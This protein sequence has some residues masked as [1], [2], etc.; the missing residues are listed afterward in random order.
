MSRA[1]WLYVFLTVA[2]MPLWRRQDRSRNKQPGILLLQVHKKTPPKPDFKP[3]QLNINAACL[4]FK[5]KKKKRTKAGNQDS[6]DDISHSKIENMVFSRWFKWQKCFFFFKYIRL[7]L[8]LSSSYCLSAHF[9]HFGST[10]GWRIFKK[11]CQALAKRQSQTAVCTCYRGNCFVD[12]LLTCLLKFLNLLTA[13]L[14]INKNL[15]LY[16]SIINI[17]WCKCYNRCKNT[18]KVAFGCKL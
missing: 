4:D 9:H 5:K 11:V 10:T 8:L 6:L 18:G 3:W 14:S 12:A 2:L 16:T 1:V 13:T 7:L 17:A 15:L